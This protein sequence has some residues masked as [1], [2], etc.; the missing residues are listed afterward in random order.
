MLSNL[1]DRLGLDINESSWTISWLMECFE[2]GLIDEDDIDGIEPRWGDSEAVKALLKKIAL[3]EGCGDW[4]AEGVMRA[5]QRLGGEAPNLGIYTLKGAS[6]RSHDHRGR[7]YEML[8]TCLSN[9]ST[10]ET[11][12]GLPPALPGKPTLKD[13]FSPEEISTVN[14]MTGG[15]RQFEDCLGICRFCSTDPVLV[16]D[17]V[18][19]A[20]GWNLSL[21]GALDIGYRA[22]NLLRLFNFRH[23]LDV[24]LEAPSRRYASTPVDGPVE[25]KG[26]AQHFESMKRNHWRLMGWDEETGMPLPETLQRLGIENPFSDEDR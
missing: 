16:V 20:T 7:W 19:A 9:T 13:Q 24:T 14:A 12:F 15:W 1:A 21:D 11:S 3:R 25:G 22:I 17:C 18:N 10:I 2:K 4:L 8:D 23:G 6:P 5:S 26:I